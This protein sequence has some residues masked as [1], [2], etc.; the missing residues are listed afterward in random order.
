MKILW[1]SN[2]PCSASGKLLGASYTKGGW[3]S[4]L[5]GALANIEDIQLSVAFYWVKRLAPFKYKN[6]F[7]Y[8]VLRSGCSTVGGRLLNKYLNRSDDAEEIKRLLFIVD[9]V[10]PDVIHIHGTEDNYGLIQAHTRIPVVVSIQGI[11]NAIALKYFSGI[12]YS[13]VQKYEGLSPK[14]KASSVKRLYAG[15][16]NNAERERMILS[17]SRNIIGRTLWDR[18]I[19]RVL[20]PQS[21]YF[22]VQEMLRPLF[23]GKEWKKREF[24]QPLRLVSTL[25]PG[26]YKGLETVVRTAQILKNTKRVDFEW[27]LPGLE[28]SNAIVKMVKRWLGVDYERIGIRFVGS[29][30]APELVDMLV[31][32]DIY[33]QTS[34]IEN[35]PNSLCEAMLIGM[36]CIASFVGGT[37]SLL[38]DG[39]EGLL[40]QD[41][42]PYAL[43]GAIFQLY[44][45]FEMA[46]GYAA[47]ARRR[48]LIRHDE[49]EILQSTLHVYKQLL[50]TS[51]PGL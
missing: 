27:V 14:L 8:P 7:Y 32:S 40:V 41:G 15:V 10:Q 30:S 45:D 35:S 42:D 49:T 39:E 24:F 18:R 51:L 22:V 38:T 19:T 23:F 5:E 17:M 34:H 28:A 12:P 9:E 26:F 11:L 13:V 47:N 20:A 36:P 6:T 48:A 37:D 3:L 25:G 1:F 43:A 21:E 33:V 50:A 16:K 4:S 31:T 46:A 29:K 2:T 44:N